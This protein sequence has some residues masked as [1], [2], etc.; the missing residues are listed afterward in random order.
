[1]LHCNEFPVGSVQGSGRRARCLP[2]AQCAWPRGLHVLLSLQN[3]TTEEVT[4][5]EEDE[6]E[7]AEVGVSIGGRFSNFSSLFLDQC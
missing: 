2:E 7:M 1:M 3:G 6:E 5:E 4:S